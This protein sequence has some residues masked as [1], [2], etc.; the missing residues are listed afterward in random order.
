MNDFE[1]VTPSFGTKSNLC[2]I[3]KEKISRNYQKCHKRNAYLGGIMNKRVTIV[4]SFM[5]DLIAY[6]SRMPVPGETIFG[7][8]F[9]LGAGGKG[10]NQAVAASKLGA[11]TNIV[12]R[13]GKDVFGDMFIEDLKKEGI[14]GEF[15]FRDGELTGIA[16][17]NVVDDGSNSIIIVPGANSNLSRHDIYNARD[18][19]INTDIL[20]LQLEIP[21]EVCLEA[22]KSVDKENTLVILNPA[23]YIGEINEE[24]LKNT[25]IL[26]PNEIEFEKL[27]RIKIDEIDKSISKIK[28]ILSQ[29]NIKYLIITV[30][31]NGVILISKDDFINYDAVTANINT[32]DTTG[33]GDAFVGALA[34]YLSSNYSIYDSIKFSNICAGLSTSKVGTSCS[35]PIIKD[36][37]EYI[38]KNKYI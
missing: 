8:K 32:I 17:I 9:H 24:L 1:K 2:L 31:K 11:S 5:V 21:M 4:G 20:V 6:T 15:V 3:L 37:D 25:S 22:A 7:N 33:A 14:G 36:I 35:Y 18:L 27:F 19:L 26:V 38:R 28:K 29:F 13:I 10:H 34:F 16:Q 12:G 30:G 23:P